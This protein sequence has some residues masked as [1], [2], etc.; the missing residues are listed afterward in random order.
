MRPSTWESRALVALLVVHT[1]LGIYYAVTVPIFESYDEIGHYRF[2]RYVA[3]ERRL[4][5]PTKPLIA[6]NDETH[7]PPL[8]YLLAAIP[9]T[10]ADLGEDTSPRLNPTCGLDR[11]LEAPTAWSTTLSQSAGLTGV[12]RWPSAWLVWSRC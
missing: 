2:V 9:L 6:E 3:E 8:Y 12:P 7:Q 1:V 4:P 5:D 11:S 10:L